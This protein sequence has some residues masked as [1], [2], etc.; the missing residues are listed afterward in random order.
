MF[1]EWNQFQVH[2]TALY[3]IIALLSQ[4]VDILLFDI[5]MELVIYTPSDDNV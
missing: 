5:M 4:R 1:S 3:S 2:F